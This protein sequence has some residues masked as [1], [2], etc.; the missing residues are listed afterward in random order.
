MKPNKFMDRIDKHK[1]NFSSTVSPMTT[2]F[3]FLL[4][5]LLEL[6]S[7]AHR[8]TFAGMK[9]RIINGEPSKENEFPY[10]VDLVQLNNKIVFPICGGSVLH[11]YLIL[12]AAHCLL[13][14]EHNQANVRK[15]YTIFNSVDLKKGELDK[16]IAGQCHPKWDE[17]LATNDI[18]LLKIAKGFPDTLLPVKLP[19]GYVFPKDWTTECMIIGWGDRDPSRRGQ[20]KKPL[21]MYS[22]KNLKVSCIDNCIQYK[23]MVP[24]IPIDACFKMVLKATN[25]TRILKDGSQTCAY[26]VNKDACQGD[27]GGPLICDGIQYG[28]VSWGIGC[29]RFDVPGIYTN[30]NFYANWILLNAEYMLREKN[31]EYQEISKRKLSID[32]SN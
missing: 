4:I 12:T 1:L 13:C 16:V 9:R 23:A 3:I 31:T 2:T 18:A 28:I 27:S 15:L 14:D 32:Y 21:K 5:S 25:E 22:I 10:V 24:L 11:K 17:N 7:C 6:S 19:F 30:V 26:G 29:G 20:N 8:K